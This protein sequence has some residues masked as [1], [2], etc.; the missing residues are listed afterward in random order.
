MLNR[1]TIDLRLHAI[2]TE[3]A[4]LRALLKEDREGSLYAP[5]VVIYHEPHEIPGFSEQI[6]RHRVFAPKLKAFLQKR[7]AS[8]YAREEQKKSEFLF[9]HRKWAK[10]LRSLEASDPPVAIAPPT[11]RHQESITIG[12]TSSRRRAGFGDAV[13]S[14]EEMNRVLLSLLEQDRDN[15]ATRWM[16]TLAVTTKM[17]SADAKHI[18]NNVFLDHNGLVQNDVNFNPEGGNLSIGSATMG[19]HNNPVWT[20]AEQK[21]FVDKFLAYP[22]NFRK[23][24]SFLCHKKTSDCVAFYYRNKKRLRLKQL[25]RMAISEANLGKAKVPSRR[26]GGPGRP[27]KARKPGRPPKRQ[28]REPLEMPSSYETS[29]SEDASSLTTTATIPYGSTISATVINRSED[30][31]GDN[32]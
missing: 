30:S 15:P 5:P 11:P 3:L 2:D 17:L 9:I 7:Y 8:Q 21:T 26:P 6:E 12:V 22:K 14:E 32:E 29:G 13:R 31:Y 24:A 27:P 10:R 4:H 16:A 25:R 19:V 20:E 1:S 28:Q 18:F 23:I